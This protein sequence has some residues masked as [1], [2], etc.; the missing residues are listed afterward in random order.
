MGQP[1]A[2]FYKNWLLYKRAP[3]GNCCELLVPV[4]FALFI[5]V[6]RNLDKA[7]TYSEQDFITNATYAR[8]IVS[9]SAS[10]PSLK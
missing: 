7:V 5:I 8:T 2:L 4:F 10:N 1:S 3:L 6:V 9:E